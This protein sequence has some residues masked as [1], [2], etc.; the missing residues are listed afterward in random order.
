MS[1]PTAIAIST[2]FEPMRQSARDPAKETPVSDET[3]RAWRNSFAYDP[4]TLNA[5]VEAVDD[6]S[7]YYRKEKITL[8][9]GRE[10]V[11]AWLFLPK[12]SS[13]PYQTVIYYLT[14]EATFNHDG[15]GLGPQRS[16][17]FIMRSGR[18]LLNPVYKGTYERLGDRPAGPNA[19]RELMIQRSQ[20]PRSFR[21]SA[22]SA[23]LRKT[24]RWFFMKGATSGPSRPRRF[25]RC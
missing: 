7:E 14:G 3:F 2:R 8:A 12:I 21:S 16:L 1:L 10:R 11:L 9:Y 5:K 4:T 13:P 17:L 6:T 15:T 24:R 22:F 23:H 19:Q 25:A 18:A 20:P